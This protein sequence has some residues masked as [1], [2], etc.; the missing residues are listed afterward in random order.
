MWWMN[1]PDSAFLG[2]GE[3]VDGPGITARKNRVDTDT[4]NM[5]CKVAQ[6]DVVLDG[7]GFRE[8]DCV[9]DDEQCLGADN[10]W[11][12]PHKSIGQKR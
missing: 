6:R 4:S 11:H 5:H 2:T 3:I 9:C 7:F 1:I 10:E 12:T 8:Q